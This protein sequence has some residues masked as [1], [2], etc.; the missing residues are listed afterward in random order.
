MNRVTRGT[1]LHRAPSFPF[2]CFS[3]DRRSIKEKSLDWKKG[4]EK[5]KKREERNKKEA[6]LT[7]RGF[8][9]TWT[10]FVPLW[11]VKKPAIP[12]FLH[13]LEV[14]VMVLAAGQIDGLRS[15][16]RCD[17]NLSRILAPLSHVSVIFL[18]LSPAFNCH[19]FVTR[20]RRIKFAVGIPSATVD[21]LWR[22]LKFSFNYDTRETVALKAMINRASRKEGLCMRVCV[23]NLRVYFLRLDA[24]NTKRNEIDGTGWHYDYAENLWKFFH[25]LFQLVR[26]K[27]LVKKLF[28]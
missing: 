25:K 4:K 10:K 11:R 20:W 27:R 21:P 8:V 26:S 16:V 2:N 3:I 22:Q 15:L 18:I 12:Y 6:R 19:L 1:F 23:L 24:C 7:Y 28:P 17:G 9:S 5:K 14:E 13:Q